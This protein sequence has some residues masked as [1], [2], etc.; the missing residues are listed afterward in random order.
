M[1]IFA[2]SDVGKLRNLNEDSYYIPEE[3]LG[4]DIFVLSDGMGGHNAG[5]VASALATSAA[6]SYIVNNYEFTFNEKE[7]IQ[8]LINGAVEYANMI[9]YEK[10]KEDE[11]YK[12][13][14]ATLEVV[15]I[16]Q[17]KIY[18]AHAG[19]SRI[20]RLRKDIF[21][22][23]TKDHSYIEK[24]VDEGK[25]SK[26]EAKNHPD[27]NMI[28]KAIGNG[29]IVEA[30]IIYKKFVKGDTLLICSDGLTNMVEEDRIKE[31]LLNTPD[32]VNIAQKLVDEANNNGGIDN[33]T[34][35][36]IKK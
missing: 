18:I 10:S 3:N 12:K 19:D 29:M 21:R 35:I 28:T 32:D 22:K 4:I 24:L 6:K 26:E 17:D 23:L 9:V 7:D 15:L 30:D 25:I 2:K 13:M 36:V 8:K 16:I 11:K 20:Y 27:K 5:E 31:I 1:K 34:V 33:I 14:G